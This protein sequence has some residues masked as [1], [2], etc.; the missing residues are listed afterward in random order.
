[1]QAAHKQLALVLAEGVQPLLAQSVEHLQGEVGHVRDVLVVGAEA[2]GQ[3]LHRLAA[4]VVEERR[5]AV[6]EE[7]LEED[8]LAQARLGDLQLLEAPAFHRGR[9]HQRAAEDHVR[10]GRA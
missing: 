2:V 9:D 10:R 3:V 5:V 6:L 4:H 1:M 7:P 8:P